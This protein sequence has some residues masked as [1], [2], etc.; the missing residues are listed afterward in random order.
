MLPQFIPSP[1]LLY[2]LPDPSDVCEQLRGAIREVQRH[3][4]LLDL[5]ERA[6]RYRE[7]VAARR[8]WSS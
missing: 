6:Q 8:E 7:R 3:R 2:K 5:A 4:G 1:D